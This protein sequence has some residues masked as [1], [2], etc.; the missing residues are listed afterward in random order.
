[1]DGFCLLVDLHLEGSAVNGVIP[2][3]FVDCDQT[4]PWAIPIFCF[5]PFFCKFEV[6]KGFH[7]KNPLHEREVCLRE[8]KSVFETQIYMKMG[9][10]QKNPSIQNLLY[11]GI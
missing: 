10:P 11:K 2:S 5:T 3:S 4:K 9:I 8:L 6:K 7:T 1:M